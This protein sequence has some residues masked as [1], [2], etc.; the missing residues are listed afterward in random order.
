MLLVVLN[1]VKFFTIKFSLA[2][3]PQ[4]PYKAYPVQALTNFPTLFHTY[5]VTP[6]LP[7]HLKMAHPT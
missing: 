6:R 2:A 4:T 3:C 5:A 1:E 7:D